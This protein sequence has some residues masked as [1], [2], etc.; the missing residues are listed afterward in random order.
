[1]CSNAAGLVVVVLGPES[2]HLEVP[3][4]DSS[5]LL[6]AGLVMGSS[7]RQRGS[8]EEDLAAWRIGGR[9]ALVGVP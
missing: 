7:V 6:W 2:R 5:A 4:K 3:E 9:K 8:L 1:M